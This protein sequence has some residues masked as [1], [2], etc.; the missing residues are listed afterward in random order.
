MEGLEEGTEKGKRKSFVKIKK[1]LIK[2]KEK[3]L[4]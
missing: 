4:I 2:K 3:A 1:Y